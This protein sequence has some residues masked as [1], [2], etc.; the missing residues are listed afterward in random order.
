MSGLWHVSLG[1]AR[2][3]IDDASRTTGPHLTQRRQKL[4]IMMM[5]QK[6]CIFFLGGLLDLDILDTGASLFFDFLLAFLS[7]RSCSPIIQTRLEMVP[8][9]AGLPHE[10]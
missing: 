9:L 6:F 8:L 5:G 2:A 4:S 7:T 10:A 3:K 1:A